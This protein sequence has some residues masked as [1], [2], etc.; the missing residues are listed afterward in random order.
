MPNVIA[1]ATTVSNGTIKR[2]NFLIGV[3]TSVIY[4]P[5]STTSFW[6]GITPPSGGYTVY[7]QKSSQGPSIRTA[8]NDSEL[9]VIAKQYGGTSVTTAQQALNYFNGLSNFLVTNI[10]YPNIVTNGLILNLDPGY[11]PSYPRSGSTLFD[12]SQN[13]NNNTILDPTIITW[14]SG[15]TGGGVLNFSKQ[16]LKQITGGTEANLTTTGVT[17]SVWVNFSAQT[18]TINRFIT[19]D[20]EIAQIRRNSSNLEMAV[21]AGGSIKAFVAPQS[22]TNGSW[23]NVACTYNSSTPSA[24][25]YVNG[26]QLSATTSITGALSTSSIGIKI[27][28][29]GT[30]ECMEGSMSVFQIWNRDLTGAEITSNYNALRGRFGI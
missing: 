20:S 2:N 17:L 9:V 5:T 4:G 21:N 15:A 10:D 19:I 29:E 12:L 30:T 24:V 27:S 25:M 8:S 6:N 14:S 23:Y 3:N 16:T 13:Q 22:F 26:I 1:S 18:N 28:S 11:I 7:E